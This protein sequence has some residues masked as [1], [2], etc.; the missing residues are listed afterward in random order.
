M[1]PL[2]KPL[3]GRPEIDNVLDVLNSGSLASGEWVKKFEDGFRAYIGTEHAIATSN[4]T[5]ALDIALKALDVKGGDEIIVPDFTFI[6][7]ANSVLF[8][9]A[10]PVFADIDARTF[11]IDP[12]DILA[13]ISPKTKAILGVHLFGHPFDVSA[14]KEICEDHHLHLI[15]DCAQAHGAEYRGKRVGSFGDLGCFSFYA[16]KNMTTGEGGMVTT[17]DE[18]L[19][20][21]L[22]LIINHGQSQKYLHTTLGYNYRMT[23]IQAAIGVAQLE[24][25]DRFNAQR[26]KNAEYLN[27]HLNF[28]GLITPFKNDAVKHVY[29]QYA[30]K[31]EDDFP[32]TRDEFLDYL[33]QNGIGSAVHYPYPI[34]LQP[35]YQSLG[36]DSDQCRVAMECSKAILSLPVYPGLTDDDMNYISNNIN[37]LGA[38]K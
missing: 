8:Q 33:S 6:A 12:D 1:I 10:K 29:H 23:N 27:K 19:K 14:L 13:K 31:V 38:F 24:K 11:N 22:S 30:V 36:Y 32:L 3:V 15:E 18:E 21:R 17:S 16:T 5:V 4:G 28:P 34:H 20:R 26:I 25:L 7:T 35:L 2:I 37:K 9:G